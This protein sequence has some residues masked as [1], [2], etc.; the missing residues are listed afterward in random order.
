MGKIK[1]IFI[2][3]INE[4]RGMEEDYDYQYDQWL[5]EQNKIKRD[6]LRK[7]LEQDVS[8]KQINT[9]LDNLKLK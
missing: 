2:D 4:S 5:L 1:E 8:D 9:V 6:N 3:I 7:S